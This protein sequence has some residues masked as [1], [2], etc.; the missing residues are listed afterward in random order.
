MRW[1]W[2]IAGNRQEV[3]WFRN[4]HGVPADVTLHF[5]DQGE[6]VALLDHFVTSITEETAPLCTAE[7]GLMIAKVLEAIYESSEQG[8]QVR[9]EW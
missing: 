3:K 8:W 1:E 7:Q 6:R 5:E 9:I 2:N 4:E